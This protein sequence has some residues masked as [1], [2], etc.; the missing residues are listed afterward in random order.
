MPQNNRYFTRE[1]TS[2]VS[3]RN[4]RGQFIS[5]EEG[6]RQGVTPEITRFYT[7]R[8][9]DGRRVS[10]AFAERQRQRIVTISNEQELRRTSQSTATRQAQNELEGQG[11][12]FLPVFG[13][14]IR[15]LL[16]EATTNNDNIGVIIRGNFYELDST[17]FADLQNMWLEISNEYVRLFDNL[18]GL[19]GFMVNV[20]D[21]GNNVILDLDSLSPILPEGEDLEGFPEASSDFRMFVLS[22]FNRFLR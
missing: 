6:I 17:Q 21:E 5:R 7:Y 1:L 3:Y 12:T 19:S 8:R 11:V 10:R 9:S 18:I 22:S 14:Q 15:R 4:S 20:V 2:R 16:L 13:Q